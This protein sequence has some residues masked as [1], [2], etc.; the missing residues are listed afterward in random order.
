MLRL[1]LYRPYE[2]RLDAIV[3]GTGSRNH[4]M[5]RFRRWVEWS[6]RLAL[7][8]NLTFFPAPSYS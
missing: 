7:S 5:H 8:A 3:H 6:A 2:R 4:A 1:A